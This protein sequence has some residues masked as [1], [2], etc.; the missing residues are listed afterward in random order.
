MEPQE[1]GS[2]SYD[3]RI[4]TAI[5]RDLARLRMGSAANMALIGLQTYA[6]EADRDG[7]VYANEYTKDDPTPAFP[8]SMTRH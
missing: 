3:V 5:L 8:G 2:R 1:K 4:N 6:L 7:I